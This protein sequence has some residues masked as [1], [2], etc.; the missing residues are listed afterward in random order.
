MHDLIVIGGGPA[1]IG[2]AVYAGRKKLK[3][4]LIADAIGGQSIVSD[5]IENW[6]GEIAISGFE[7]A[8]KLEKHLRTQKSVE[9]KIPEKVLKI[10]AIN[11][12]NENNDS[13]K[14]KRVCDFAVTTNK[15][16]SYSAKAVIVAS[17]ARR[18]RLGILGEDK[19]DGKGVAFCSTCDAPIFAGKDVAVVGGGNAGLEAVADLFPY[20]DKIYL[21]VRGDALKGDAV[22]QEEVKKNSKT[23]IL[24]N[25][26]PKEIFG[27]QFVLGLK[28]INTKTNEEKTL[29]IG[30]VFVE[31]GS[32]PNSEMVR[33]LVDINQY[34]EIVIDH[35]TC[36]TSHTGIFAA[37]D[38]TDELY[39]QNNISV[40]EGIIAALSAYNYILQRQ[41]QI[42][43]S[44]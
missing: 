33:G 39:K 42:P 26:I 12:I 30:G 32:V 9:I 16:S 37:G 36:A 22:T 5:K 28:Y 21:L 4:L 14:H 41:K 44:S 23:E 7:L 34:G 15:N 40:G 10:E 11:C 35:R 24:F 2:A 27:E 6:I 19:F 18:K 17:G 1:A 8:E 43:A 13:T 31:I 25:T 38:V 20:A 3:A 29:N